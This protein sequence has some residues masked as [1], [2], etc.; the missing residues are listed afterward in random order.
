MPILPASRPSDV[1]GLP[2]HV[3]TIAS[4]NLHPTTKVIKRLSSTDPWRH[5]SSLGTSPLQQ[6]T[7]TTTVRNGTAPG[8][9]PQ[10]S[11]TAVQPSVRDT[12]HTSSAPGHAPSSTVQSGQNSRKRIIQTSAQPTIVG[13]SPTNNAASCTENKN[14]SQ[15][16]TRTSTSDTRIL[17]LA[18]RCPKLG[19]FK[20]HVTDDSPSSTVN[21][22][23]TRT[24]SIIR[25][26]GVLGV[27]NFNR[28]HVI[29]EC[30]RQP[31]AVLTARAGAAPRSENM[32]MDGTV[33]TCLSGPNNSIARSVTAQ[34]GSLF[35]RTVLSIA[36]AWQSSL[37]F[38]SSSEQLLYK[39]LS[40]AGKHLMSAKKG[41]QLWH[42]RTFWSA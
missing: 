36:G 38:A 22:N 1:P 24:P 19:V 15:T 3:P 28:Q 29:L 4:P 7:R 32:V 12:K 9:N 42:M 26:P 35:S 6:S 5:D 34:I 41:L 16:S 11:A 8:H 21:V 27:S 31:L 39:G 40:F 23:H 18:I 33:S 30:L 13:F 20:R 25:V 14:P 10:P 2:G 37:S 17:D